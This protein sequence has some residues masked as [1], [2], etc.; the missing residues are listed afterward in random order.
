MTAKYPNKIACI[1]KQRGAASLIV[2]IV[3]LAVIT[4]VTIYTSK[5]IITEQKLANNDYRARQAFEA[6]EAGINAAIHYLSDDPDT[7]EDGNI[8]FIFDSDNDD[9]TDTNTATVGSNNLVQVSVSDESGDNSMT[10]LEVTSVGYSDDRSAT[11][12]IL[13]VMSTLDPLPN[14]PDNPLTTRGGVVVTGSATISNPEGASTIW[15]GD[16]VDLGSNNSTATRV[17]DVTDPG[18]PSCMDVSQSCGTVPSSNKVTVGL[19]VIEYDTN[20][21][22]LSAN[23]FFQNFFGMPPSTF[24]ESMAT[25]DTTPAN[26]DTA[27]HLAVNEI[28]WIEGN[29]TFSSSLTVGCNTAVSGGNDCASAGGNTKPSILIVNGNATFNGNPH[30]Y[31]LVFVTGSV[32]I[33]G[34]TT[35]EGALVTGGA[36]N[37]NTGG[38]LDVT[39]DG[40][41]LQRV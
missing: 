28:V 1:G 9:V 26:A 18:Y 39:Y 29:T 31:G 35:V 4:I 17:A 14:T 5:T 22:N 2:S 11:R 15:S 37:N 19:D 30:F 34:N 3:I 16:D 12:T 36:L 40:S 7:D 33:S 20:L 32:T 41:M 25:I 6:A 24:R 38:S 13:R 10:V 21:S 27:A 23:E 8:D